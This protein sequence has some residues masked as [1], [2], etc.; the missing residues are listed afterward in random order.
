M[1]MQTRLRH[2]KV[3]TKVLEAALCLGEPWDVGKG[4]P[5]EKEPGLSSQWLS[6]S[7]SDE[8][9]VKG[10]SGRGNSTLQ[11]CPGRRDCSSGARGQGEM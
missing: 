3:V 4:L 8:K 2:G 5:A 9:Q 1:F 11:R 10:I 7:S 6:G